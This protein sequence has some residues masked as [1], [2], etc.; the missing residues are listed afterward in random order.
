MRAKHEKYLLELTGL[1]T[2]AGRED[3]V[4]AWV[5]HWAGRR[6]T[7]GL[8]RDK[9]G[10]LLLKRAGAK[11]NKPII[12]TAHMDHPAFVVTGQESPRRITA[13]FRGGVDDSY[14]VGSRVRLHLGGGIEPCRGR[15]LKLEPP[16]EAGGDKRVLVELVRPVVAEVG[17]VMV[18]DL[19]APKI[20]RG[21]LRAPVCDD[22]AG[23]AAGLAAF[24]ALLKE[25]VNR[26]H[27][28]VRL[29]L[30]R[31]EE[32]GFIGAIG[33]CKSGLIPKGARLIALENSRSF[34]ESPIGGGPIIRVGDRT[35]SFDPDLT[36]RIGLVAQS[37]Q[38]S[39]PDFKWQRKLMP[40][41]T[42]EAS[43]YQALGY[44]ATC[45]CLPLGNYH[46][47]KPKA[48]ADAS[49]DN[50]PKTTGKSKGKPGEK[51]GGG[52]LEIAGDGGGRGKID[53][54]TI[55]VADYHGLIRLL[56]ETGRRLDD[57]TKAPTLKDRLGPLFARRRGLLH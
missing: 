10:N 15:V 11:S 17:D 13:E 38:Q 19:P 23:V 5:E 40:G 42:C 43:A 35:S 36:Y 1:P 34:A 4:I 14:F 39:D 18:W 41:G 12:I 46:N 50:K 29:L 6:K 31:A 45:L 30:T 21:R 28:D 27:L 32:V 51:S 26:V 52:G 7:V 54:E 48:E 55:A 37:I 16:K 2:A 47:M 8:S 25:R 33:A 44:T 9:F 49:R 56:I 24:E 20:A 53:S 57:K 22:L 3:R